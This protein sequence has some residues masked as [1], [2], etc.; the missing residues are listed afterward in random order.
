MSLLSADRQARLWRDL[1]PHWHRWAEAMAAPAAKLNAALIDAL[2]PPPDA[3]VVD[4][5]SGAG[6]P[7]L[8]LA[9]RL[10]EGGLLVASDLVVEMLAGL[11]ARPAAGRLVC[12]AADMGALPF[13]D[14]VASAVSCRFGLMF[15]PDPHHALSEAR[16]ILTPGGRAA[17]MVWGPVAEN[18]LFTVLEQ[19]MAAVFGHDFAEAELPLFRFAEPGALHRALTAAGFGTIEETALTPR[20][21]I[22][23]GTPFWRPQLDMLFGARLRAAGPA[24]I[25]ALE[26]AIEEALVAYRQ[27]DQWHMPLHARLAVGRR[28]AGDDPVAPRQA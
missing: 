10:G 19:A 21:R 7:A 3:V 23:C 27:G 16:R 8:G 12:V 9:A 28:D 25:A 1:S 14:R 6:E 22:P 26:E 5:A 4:L 18:G 13:A 2:A 20:A 17:F 15:C 11:Q 24:Q